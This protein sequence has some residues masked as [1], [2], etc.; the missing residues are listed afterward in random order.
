MRNSNWAA[1]LAFKI[2]YEKLKMYD[3]GGFGL[4]PFGLP[5]QQNYMYGNSS[6]NGSN[7]CC[8]CCC[9]G[10][11]EASDA[12]YRSQLNSQIDVKIG[13]ENTYKCLPTIDKP[14]SEGYVLL[15][16]V[17]WFKFHNEH[18]PWNEARKQCF[19]EG[20]HLA[21]MESPQETQWCIDH[22]LR[23]SEEEL[24]L[25]IHNYFRGDWVSVSDTDVEKMKHLKWS[26]K[27]PD[28]Y[29]SYNCAIINPKNKLVSRESCTV[30]H[31]FI[32]KVP[33]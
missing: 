27:E 6:N 17:G 15:E 4:P 32:C 29:R 2:V 10:E 14:P 26:K 3:S 31:P 25:G 21:F 28:E 33:L 12:S 24:F 23:G 8:G 22:L 20:A 11:D 9:D 7:D 30:D 19:R 16:N 18:K 1:D 13:N 5:L